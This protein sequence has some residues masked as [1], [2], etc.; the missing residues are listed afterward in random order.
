M[1]IS[2][3]SKSLLVMVSIV[4]LGFVTS[5]D[6]SESEQETSEMEPETF[7]KLGYW[8]GEEFIELHVAE[9]NIFYVQPRLSDSPIS[10]EK[11]EEILTSMNVTS[12]MPRVLNNGFLVEMLA[13]PQHPALY[14]SDRYTT[15]G[16][17]GLWVIPRITLCVASDEELDGIL[18]KYGELL[19]QTDY[20]KV[21][22]SGCVYRFTC[23]LA[24]SAEVLMLASSIHSEPTVKWCEPSKMSNW[25]LDSASDYVADQ[26]ALC[27]AWQLIGYGSEKSFHMIDEEYRRRDERWGFRFFLTFMDE[28][29]FHGRDA[30]N[31]FD[32]SYT[33]EGSQIE[34]RAINSTA[35]GDSSQETPEFHNRLWSSTS[36]GIK[37]GNKL[38]LYYSEDEFLYFEAR[39]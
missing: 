38:R 32:A 17:D 25:S 29:R 6:K 12:M 27:Q 19:T 22:T 5:C 13:R 8:F 16:S 24:T 1:K 20:R 31:S 3:I 34:L 30:V 26:A 2:F 18:E 4:I 14:V 35:I 23:D 10:E 15:E 36:Y 11:L 39:R 28:G 37:D 7:V 9:P 21:S 33:C